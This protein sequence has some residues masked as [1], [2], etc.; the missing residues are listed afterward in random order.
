MAL[1]AP[2]VR[3]PTSFL[4]DS[5]CWKQHAWYSHHNPPEWI[6]ELS[7]YS[8]FK[9]KSKN[10]CGAW[11]NGVQSCDNTCE[12][13]QAKERERERAYWRVVGPMLIWR[14]LREWCQVA[15]I[16]RTILLTHGAHFTDWHVSKLQL[17]LGVCTLKTCA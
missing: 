3:S 11:S 9:S 10:I 7:A 5:R 2:H 13:Q 1:L 12:A 17:H 16:V 8:Y 14:E 4:Q 6:H 15:S